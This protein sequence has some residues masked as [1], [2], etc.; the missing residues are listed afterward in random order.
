MRYE[1]VVDDVD[2]GGVEDDANNF[3]YSWGL[4][5]LG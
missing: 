1:T 4:D 3:D 2:E 5:H